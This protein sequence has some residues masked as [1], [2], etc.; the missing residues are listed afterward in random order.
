MTLTALG[1]A[2]LAGIALAGWLEPPL[3]VLGVLALPALAV[4]LLWRKDPGPRL[5]AACALALLAGGA[6]LL[7]AM[8]HFGPDDLAYYNDQGRVELIGVVTDEPDVR[9]TYQNLRVRAEALSIDPVGAGLPQRGP[10]GASAPEVGARPTPTADERPISGL[11][12]V[13]APRYPARAYGDRL[14][15]TGKLET[16]PIYEGF[17]YRD[18]LARQGVYSI[19]SRPNIE[20]IESGQGSPFWTALYAFKARAQATIAQ[21]L[22]EPYAALLTGILLGVESGI[23]RALYE[24]FNATGTSHIIVISGNNFAFI[25]A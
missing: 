9:D 2:W 22:P 10:A 13:Q 20:L 6:R 12:L 18:Y 3:P 21:I 25:A 8:P 23:P 5:A 17:S 15:V 1:L 24:R 11:V 14:A 4:L 16:P 19:I 7:V